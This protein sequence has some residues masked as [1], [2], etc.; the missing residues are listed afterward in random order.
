M[1]FSLGLATPS[2]AAVKLAAPPPDAFTVAV[3]PEDVIEITRPFVVAHDT[4][5]SVS[6][7][8]CDEVGVA[9]RFNVWPRLNVTVLPAGAPPITT[10]VTGGR[11][12]GPPGSPGVYRS[13]P[14]SNV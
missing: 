6:A 11:C 5:R 8:P 1:K 7:S 4:G 3:N 12:D 14:P 10:L 2:L 9:V 13:T